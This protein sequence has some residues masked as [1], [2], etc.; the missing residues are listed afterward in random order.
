MKGVNFNE[1]VN[2]FNCG[3]SSIS[4]YCRRC[5][6]VVPPAEQNETSNL[7]KA[8]STEVT[9]ELKNSEG[10][11]LGGGYV[12]Y[13]G[14]GPGTDSRNKWS[15]L[16]DNDSITDV[17]YGKVIGNLSPGSYWFSVKYNDTYAKVKQDIVDGE[18]NVVLFTTTSVTLGFSGNITYNSKVNPGSWVTGTWTPSVE[19]SMEMLPDTYAF[20][21][22]DE[23]YPWASVKIEV[24][25]NSVV[26]TVAYIRLLNSD[27]TPQPNYT[28][29]WC[30]YGGSYAP[31]VGTPDAKGVLLNVMDG[32]NDWVY[33]YHHIEYL[34][35]RSYYS[36]YRVPVFNSFYDFQLTKVE[37]QLKDHAGDLMIGTGPKV[38]VETYYS[39]YY[40]NELVEIEF[41]TLND[42]TV[43]K[44]LLVGF[45]HYFRIKD[46]NGTRQ[47]IQRDWFD[48]TLPIVFQTFLVQDNGWGCTHY[49]Q[50]GWPYLP[51]W[52]PFPSGGEIELLPKLRTYYKNDVGA[53]KWVDVLTGGQ[54]LNLFTVSSGTVMP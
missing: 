22:G 40:P 49:R 54:I 25:G 16:G 34:N 39:K 23:G 8:G 20:R 53:T 52:Q 42:G 50:Y 19:S 14:K 17:V 5:I 29:T 10:E 45:R 27:G 31:V 28:A 7:M 26:K 30:T 32:Y 38:Y 44:D 41:G 18:S 51:Y 2:L 21:F 3:N 48:Y 4:S 13:K 35:S 47:M 11:P 46:Y 6:P 43:S 1:K 15:P 24:S 9:V 36:L 12:E 37:V 33:A